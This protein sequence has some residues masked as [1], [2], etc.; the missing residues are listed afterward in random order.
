MPKR[1]GKRGEPEKPTQTRAFKEEVGLTPVQFLEQ[2]RMARARQ[3]LELTGHG[4]AEIAAMVGYE[5]A[6]YFTR[7]FT[8]ATGKSPRAYRG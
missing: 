3:L 1:S 2:Q 7:R 8:R 6:F 4:V 5:N